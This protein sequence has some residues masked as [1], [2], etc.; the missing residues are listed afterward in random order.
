VLF[1]LSIRSLP[2]HRQAASVNWLGKTA[3]FTQRFPR[4]FVLL[5]IEMVYPLGLRRGLADRLRVLGLALKFKLEEARAA[6]RYRH[7]LL[8]SLDTL[9]ENRRQR[10][11]LDQFTRLI[12]MVIDDRSWI[13]A[14]TVVNR[15]QQLDGMH[16]ILERS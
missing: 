10:V 14:K 6:Q 5:G 15:C 8:M 9:R 2:P 11:R 1:Q 16:G 3:T 7:L 4:A 12:E 13:D